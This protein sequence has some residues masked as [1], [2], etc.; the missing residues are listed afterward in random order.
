MT[1]LD[2]RDRRRAE[3]IIHNTTL[4]CGLPDSECLARAIAA[5]LKHERE[6]T[7]F[8]AVRALFSKSAKSRKKP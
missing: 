6:E 1:S 4:A 3:K 8:A 5:A 7:G 2:R